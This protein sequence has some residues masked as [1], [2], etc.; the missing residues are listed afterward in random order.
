MWGASRGANDLASRQHLAQRFGGRSPSF[1]VRLAKR[2][3]LLANTLRVVARRPLEVSATLVQIERLGVASLPIVFVTS[4]V[5]G[6]VMAT[7]FAFGLQKFGGMEYTS[8]VVALSFAQEI[9]PTF[10]GIIV[11]SR[12]GAGI[13]AELGSMAVT[14]QLDAIRALGADP[15]K[16]LV[17]P[18]LVACIVVMPILAG[19][20]LAL[21]FVAAM[22]ITDIEFAIPA[23]FFVSSA[24]Q[25]VT[26][27]DYVS[28]MMKA[29]VFGVIT[30]IG[31][32]H[33]GMR[34]RSGTAG[35]GENTTLAVVAIAITTL[36]A[37]F[38]LTKLGFLIWPV[39]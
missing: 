23:R 34:T 12:I 38:M 32:C 4:V 19:V 16:K 29:P 8:R 5:M 3:L 21:G 35:V 15:H 17:V 6:M 26:L 14:E 36:V 30:A 31:A 18:R 37:D 1:S 9:A 7:Q 39:R 22:L 25:S 20:S 13:A 27:L 10:V 28:G 24:L 11:A 2:P 33:F